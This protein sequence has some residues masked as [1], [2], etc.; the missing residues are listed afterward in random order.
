MKIVIDQ[1]QKNLI[2]PRLKKFRADFK[3]TQEE[4]ST[5]L[6]AIAIYLDRSSISKIERQNRIVTDFEL[7]AIAAVLKVSVNVLIGMDD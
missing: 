6:K 1:N 4:L 5:S 3:I 2:G 7:I